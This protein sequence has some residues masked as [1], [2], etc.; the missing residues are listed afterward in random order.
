MGYTCKL[1]KN[2]SDDNNLIKETEIIKEVQATMKNDTSILE[3]TFTILKDGVNF[4]YLNYLY[5]VELE[6]YYFVNNIKLVKGG[7]LEIS[8]HE[9]VLYSFHR[10]ILQQKAIIKRQEQEYNTY[11]PDG[12]F[13]AYAYPLIQQ[14][15]F[16]SGFTDEPSIILTLAGGTNNG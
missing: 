16:P 1:M 10:G 6:R 9:D 11:I 7:L 12:T 3:P 2:L 14:K 15:I 4:N 8:C 5:I 13:K